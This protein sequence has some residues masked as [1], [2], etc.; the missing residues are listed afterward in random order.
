MIHNHYKD[1]QKERRGSDSELVRNNKKFGDNCG[2]LTDEKKRRLSQSEQLDDDHHHHHPPVLGSTNVGTIASLP[3]KPRKEK[4]KTKDIFKKDS[5]KNKVFSK[6]LSEK[7]QN[8][9]V[10]LPTAGDMNMEAKFKQGLLEGTMDKG[11]PR[12]PHRTE[13][14]NHLVTENS[15]VEARIETTEKV[16]Y[17]IQF[18]DMDVI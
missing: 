8:K 11:V 12:P 5:G 16:K 1:K 7:P 10:T 17:V 13:A 9:V 14:V 18:V 15:R 2:I 4:L 6:S 3:Q